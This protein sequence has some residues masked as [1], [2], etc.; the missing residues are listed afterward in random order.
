[1]R[2]QI[3]SQVI[4]YILAAVVMS[5]VLIFGYQAIQTITKNMEMAQFIRFKTDLSDGIT[6]IAGR[7]G[8]SK[9]IELDCP[10]KFTKVCF[11]DLDVIKVDEVNDESSPISQ[12]KEPLIMYSINDMVNP[13]LNFAKRNVFLCPPCTEQMYVGRIAFDDMDPDDP[14]MCFA[15][16]N[17]KLT[18]TVEGLGDGTRIS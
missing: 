15:P 12:I 7:Y 14:F 16:S 9:V 11:V 17:G 10:A 4:V 2:A 18:L 3:Q 13:N 6:S 8:S 5:L 1:M